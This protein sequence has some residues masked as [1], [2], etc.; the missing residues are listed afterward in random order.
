MCAVFVEREH[1]L[2]RIITDFLN[3]A[4]HIG[5]RGLCVFLAH[6]FTMTALLYLCT[7][8]FF[9]KEVVEGMGDLSFLRRDNAWSRTTLF[10]KIIVPFELDIGSMDSHG[11]DAYHEVFASNRR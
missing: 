6:G 7:I 8:I 1:L 4:S 11:A 9:T 2:L 5:S 10:I 3:K